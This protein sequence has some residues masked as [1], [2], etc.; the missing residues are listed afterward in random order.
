MA[1]VIVS[2]AVW[3]LCLKV[4]FALTDLLWAVVPRLEFAIYIRDTRMMRGM[5]VL[6]ILV[7]MTVPVLVRR[8][9]WGGCLEGDDPS[10]NQQ[11]GRGVAYFGVIYKTAWT[12]LMKE[13]RTP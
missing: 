6:P 11:S 3:P 2:K 13:V 5:C 10:N 12:T 1:S 7:Q 8:K 4:E 9:I